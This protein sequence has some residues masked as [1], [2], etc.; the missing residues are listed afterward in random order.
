MT[1]SL[2][3]ARQKITAVVTIARIKS[4]KESAW[5]AGGI[6]FLLNTDEPPD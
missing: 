2:I 4:I 5:W 6:A 1:T 3:T